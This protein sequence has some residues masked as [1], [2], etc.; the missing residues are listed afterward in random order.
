MSRPEP[1][2]AVVP[3]VEELNGILEMI[4]DDR[5]DYYGGIFDLELDDIDPSRL[6]ND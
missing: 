6:L 4:E 1:K 3:T 5:R 2:D